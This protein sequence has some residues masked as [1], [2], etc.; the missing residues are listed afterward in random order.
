MHK[1]N[2]GAGTI[3][4]L[5][6]MTFVQ[7]ELLYDNGGDKMQVE[8]APQFIHADDVREYQIEKFKILTEPK[9]SE[10][11]FGE[12]LVCE[13]YAIRKDGSKER[14]KWT[15]NDRTRTVLIDSYGKETSEW[16]GKELD[17]S[18]DNKAIIGTVKQ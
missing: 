16:I 11:N 1:I 15:I 18:T 2:E 5:S 7:K 4:Q 12:Q 13:V 17:I 10:G 3:D 9:L 6:S 14:A 8:K